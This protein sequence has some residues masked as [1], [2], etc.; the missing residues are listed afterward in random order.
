MF[1]RYHRDS[2]LVVEG[3][4]PQ[5]HHDATSGQTVFLDG[6]IHNR[7]SLAEKLGIAVIEHTLPS[8]TEL[9]LAAY[10]S[11]GEDCGRH[12]LGEFV[13]AIVDTAVPQIFCVRDAIGIKPFFYFLDGNEFVCGNDVRQVADCEAVPERLCDEAVAIYLR[14][15]ELY[16]PEL[17]FYE[18]IRK[19]PPAH[20]ITVGRA[21]VKKQKYWNLNDCPPIELNSFEAYSAR[22]LELLEDAVKVRLDEGENLGVHLSG[23]LDS[24]TIT[25]LAAPAVLAQGCQVHS[26]SWMSPPENQAELENPEWSVAE[27]VAAA[28]GTQHHYTD[29]NSDDILHILET[30]NLADH[31]SVDLWYE[32][33]VRNQARQ[34]DV[35]TILSG[36]GGDQFITAYG[37]DRYAETF[38]RGHVVSSLIDLY[39]ATAG[40]PGRL[41]HFISLFLSEIVLPVLP[42]WLLDRSGESEFYSR[43]YLAASTAEFEAVTRKLQKRPAPSPGITL[44]GQQLD[45]YEINH[46]VNRLESWAVSGKRVGI[47]YR[48]PLLDKRLVEFALGLPADL[49]RRRGIPRYLFRW[50]VSKLL[51]RE[52]WEGSLKAEPLRVRRLMDSSREAVLRWREKQEECLPVHPYIDRR[53][54]YNLIDKIESQE[55][56]MEVD[57]IFMVVTAIKSILV[58]NIGVGG[59]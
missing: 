29:L 53:R 17:T 38:W 16:H 46:L 6:Q 47:E 9:I 32:F 10:R 13:F 4:A 40:K 42:G 23:G 34:S 25:A 56:N 45:E 35:K 3:R 11:W 36:W 37:N 49:Y 22:L 44:K 30:H 1:I 52:V 27:K 28:C 50:T 8:A 31:D 7:A 2:A 43:D 12:L 21:L 59:S 41:R 20:T 14:R 54:L 33:A 48:Y 5:M 51:P 57:Y 24:S 18:A 15:G 19:L 26:Y 58:L 55:P 39:R